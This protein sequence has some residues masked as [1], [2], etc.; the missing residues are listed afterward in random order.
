MYYN[1]TKS[2]NCFL[3]MIFP[4]QKISKTF[5]IYPKKGFNDWRKLSP[6]IPDHENTFEHKSTV[7]SWKCF[8]KH[9]I[10]GKK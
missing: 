3:C 6:K 2:I 9:L 5:F 8:V 10:E 7:F 1:N 4:S